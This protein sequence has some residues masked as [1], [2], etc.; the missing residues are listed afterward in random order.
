MKKILVLGINGFTGK[1][2]QEY[3]EKKK[4]KKK[5]IFIGVDKR[6]DKSCYVKCIAADLLAKNSIENIILKE[7]PDYIMNFAGIL[8]AENPFDAIEI[9]AGLSL[10]ILETIAKNGLKVKKILLIG[11]AA[12]YGKPEYL[13]IDEKHRLNPINYYG[14]S[15][16]IQTKISGYYFNNY[17]LNICIARTFN[18][19]GRDLPDSISIGAFVKQIN[20]AKNNGKVFAGNLEAKR[21]FI[22]TEDAVAAY[23]KILMN[24]RSGEIYNVCSG[25]SIKMKE[26]LNKIIKDSGKCIKIMKNKNILNK[27]SDVPDIYGSNIK[28]KEKLGVRFNPPFLRNE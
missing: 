3:I 20:A 25:K 5:Y 26:I 11:S 27:K 10:R 17:K 6:N 15:K 1:H 7:K 8:K 22:V 21:D 4:L 18:L 13:P 24:G 9:N 12:E 14:L 2:F 28:I 19:Y 23:W 16:V